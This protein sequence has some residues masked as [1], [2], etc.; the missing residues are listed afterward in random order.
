MWCDVTGW[1]ETGN[2]PARSSYIILIDQTSTSAFVTG[3]G[4]THKGNW[5]VYK[6]K[7][8]SDPWD[9]TQEVAYCDIATRTSVSD[10]SDRFVWFTNV[11][12]VDKDYYTYPGY[13]RYY[14]CHRVYPTRH[15]TASDCVCA[16]LLGWTK[17]SVCLPSDM[18]HPP[19]PLG[20]WVQQTPFWLLH[21]FCHDTVTV[22]RLLIC[23]CPPLSIARY[24]FRSLIST[25][26][27]I[28]AT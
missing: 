10:L 15:I 9:D 20:V 6:E 4:T 19:P 1:G 7:A 28:G 27:W 12:D 17:T 14:N 24:S 23:K 3:R 25:A 21:A 5:C 18:W 8:P 2:L 22:P 16:V 13:W 26:E 11:G